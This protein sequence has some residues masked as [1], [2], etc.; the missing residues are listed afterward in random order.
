M[1]LVKNQLIMINCKKCKN[2]CI[3]TD[4]CKFITEGYCLL[5]QCFT[6]FEAHF[7][8]F[9]FGNLKVVTKDTTSNGWKREQLEGT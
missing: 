6:T 1:K 7:Q 3:I 9:E 5:V 8:F 2:C 4:Y